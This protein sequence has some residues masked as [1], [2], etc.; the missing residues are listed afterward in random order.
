MSE[1]LHEVLNTLL[2]LESIRFGEEGVRFGW[3][4]P[5][6]GWL[7][8][9]L[10][11]LALTLA[12]WVYRRLP[13]RLG[14]KG[15]LGGLRAAALVLVLVMVSG[16]ALIESSRRVEPDWILVLVDRSS[17]LQAADGPGG[18][19]RDEQLR[20]ALR[21]AW[22]AWSQR[23]ERSE[24]V[25][26]GFADGAFDLRTVGGAEASSVGLNLGEAAGGR[27]DLARALDTALDR[28]AARSVAGV[29]VISD[30]RSTSGV[31]AGV[32]DEVRARGIPI[33]SVPLGARGSTRDVTLTAEAPG[34]AFASDAVPVQVRLEQVADDAA[35]S[36]SVMVRLLDE[37]T[38]EVLD[39]R[40]VAIEG[41]RSSLTLVGTPAEAGVQRWRVEMDAGAD[42][43]VSENNSQQVQID[44]LDEPLRVVYLD[45]TPRWEHRYLK[46]L[47]LREESITSSA[48]LLA[49]RRR[50]TQEGNIALVSLPA[51]P[52]EWAEI[53]VVVL[54]DVQ[55]ELIGEETM[56]QLRDHVSSR[57]AGLVWIGGPT[58]TPHAYRGTPLAALL[59][60]A[61]S[62][63]QGGAMPTWREPV[64][65]M[66]TSGADALGVLRLGD[67][68]DEPWPAQLS[69]PM[70]GWSRL[71]G[72][73]FIEPSLL[74][75]A[76]VVLASAQAGGSESSMDAAPA[77][78][79]MRYGAG[80]VVYIAT[81]ETW[82]WRYG[83]GDLLFDRFWLPVIRM[84]GR[85]SVARLGAEAS[86]AIDPRQPIA[87]RAATVELRLLDQALVDAAG[88]TVEVEL[89]REAGAGQEASQQPGVM[90]TLRRPDQETPQLL[91]TWIADEP[92]VYR[93][94]AVTPLLAGSGLDG[95][96]RVVRADDE[97][98][99]P[100]PDHALLAEL[101]DRTG[102]RV[103][104]ADALASLP[105]E[106]P[107][108]EVVV[109]SP[110]RVQTLWDTPLMLIVL[111]TLLTAEWVVRR[112]L[113]LA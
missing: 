44:V 32:L 106:I 78:V 55:P 31:D 7:W 97:Q 109:A 77:V 8:L 29:V 12:W 63:G 45:G 102:G 96:V 70:T 89:L 33:F 40:E 41:T 110:P 108:R 91:G 83:L 84:A 81:D 105:E 53:D 87:G 25:W 10:I 42:D 24:L 76:A 85:Q 16:P 9:V 61:T 51:S 94:R 82:R 66:R 104:E 52:E 54:G 101:A 50:Y 28:T 13:L 64:T 98:R 74:K 19:S 20:E 72:V 23:S 67:T 113:K 2:G 22:P 75:P 73:Q 86:L 30:G 26:L 71:W 80:R 1:A 38:G 39:E 107:N 18:V 15:A 58:A 49:E 99:D 59:P 65:L 103:V 47:L 90:V 46:N 92:G 56:A 93:V 95:Q 111:I 79:T 69:D 48:L 36:R 62:S 100:R 57:G 27:T 43:L 37:V 4:R 3:Q 14:L 35:A 6:P 88:L 11:G 17:S 5:M 21:A 68:A 34:R 112:L 60:F